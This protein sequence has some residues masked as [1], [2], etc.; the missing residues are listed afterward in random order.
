MDW[1][2]SPGES[3]DSFTDFISPRVNRQYEEEVGESCVSLIQ[4]GRLVFWSVLA[5]NA[6]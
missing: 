5:Q 6:I 4:L 2:T 3:V 1:R